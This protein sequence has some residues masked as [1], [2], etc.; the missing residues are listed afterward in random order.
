M[1]MTTATRQVGSVTI[2]DING[3]VVLQECD[4]L[5]DLLSNLLAAGHNKILLNLADANRFDTVGLACLVRGLVSIRK[6]QGELKLLNPA[7]NVREVLR[8]T[9]LDT[10]FDIREDEAEAVISFSVKSAAASA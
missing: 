2:V 9:K 5:R 8:L 3:R 1:N 10:I 7:K 6:Q 4:S